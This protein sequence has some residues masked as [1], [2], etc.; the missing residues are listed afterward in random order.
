MEVPPGVTLRLCRA[1][2]GHFEMMVLSAM[3]TYGTLRPIDE[4][5]V[6]LAMLYG[7]FADH[8][9]HAHGVTPIDE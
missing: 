6:E 3:D 7:F 2:Q 4:V 8:L 1:K 9:E 5:N